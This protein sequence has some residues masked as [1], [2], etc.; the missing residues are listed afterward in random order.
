MKAKDRDGKINT[1]Y[2]FSKGRI[3]AEFQTDSPEVEHTFAVT[4]L[5]KGQNT[6]IAMAKDNDG[7][8]GQSRMIKVSVAE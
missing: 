2:L 3:R 8:V 6:I 4:N 1:L 7:R 5:F